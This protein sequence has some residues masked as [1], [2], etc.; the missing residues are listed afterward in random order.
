[1]G[2]FGSSANA[3]EQR[4]ADALDGLPGLY[5]VGSPV[6]IAPQLGVALGAGYG[7]TEAQSGENG[8][9][10]RVAESAA[11][12]AVVTDGLAF[13][14]VANMRSDF[15]PDDGLGADSG[16]VLDLRLGARAATAV[17]REFHLGL[18]FELRAPGA[19]RMVEALSHPAIDAGLLAAWQS[20][21]GP[22]FL[23]EAGYRK[24]LTAGSTPDAER[25][26]RGDR[27]ALGSSEYDALL[28]GLGV[29][30]T[31]DR[32]EAFAEVTSDVLIGSGAPPF[33]QSPLRLTLGARQHLSQKMTLGLVVDGTLSR[34][35]GSLPT[36]PLVPI[37]PLVSAHL[38]F[39]YR[40]LPDAAPP[41]KPAAP[42]PAPQR[43]A[44]APKAPPPAK[45]APP[46]VAPVVVRPLRVRVVDYKGHPIS[47][48][49]V[50]AEV[51]RSGQK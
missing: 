46:E 5:R 21:L 3:D 45:P 15:H 42:A 6:L 2:A 26:R 10:H 22:L 40:F 13:H 29:E 25:L 32:T 50:T 18:D 35:P 30:R 17:S 27:I 14:A 37:E 11:V 4:L 51:L 24:D 23:I 31:F 28:L 19:E 48:A 1:M 49:T 44:A 38:A 41:A 8:S 36:D 33:S 34:R 16:S 39:T 12:G 7:F 9:H 20:E 47:D 43:E